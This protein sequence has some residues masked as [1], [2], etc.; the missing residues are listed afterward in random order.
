MKRGNLSKIRKKDSK[1]PIGSRS[2]NPIQSIKKKKQA[3]KE[4]KKVVGVEESFLETKRRKKNS[5]FRPR[6]SAATFHFLPFFHFDR[7]RRSRSLGVLNKQ[8][9]ASNS[10]TCLRA[11]EV[12]KA[13]TLETNLRRTSPVALQPATKRSHTS[14]RTPEVTKKTRTA[15]KA[16]VVTGE[17]QVSTG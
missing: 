7:C 12:R 10:S 3:K 17:L 14:A 9:S 11:P 6:F 16:T 15:R 1:N 5:Q 4:A 8:T 2:Q 13:G